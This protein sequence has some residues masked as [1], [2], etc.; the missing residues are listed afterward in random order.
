MVDSR[1]VARSKQR[2]HVTVG[3]ATSFT[4]NVSRG[5]FCIELL[6]VLPPGTSVDGRIRVH[7]HEYAYAG[8]VVWSKQG[9][10]RMNIRGR[11]GIR[12]TSIAPEFLHVLEALPT[13]TS[14]GAFRNP[15]PS[16]KP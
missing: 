15:E 8:R 3:R 2:F 9:S 4:V 11:M 14:L 10:P 16:K 6:R 7:D 13:H 12:F 1:R 5:G